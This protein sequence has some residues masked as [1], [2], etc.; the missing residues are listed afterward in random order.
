MTDSVVEKA[1]AFVRRCEGNEHLMT[2][3]E[4]EHRDMC[5]ALLSSTSREE[6]MREALAKAARD[7]ADIQFSAPPAFASMALKAELAI[8]AALTAPAKGGE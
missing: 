5:A 1:R 2:Q 7:F 8:R 3:T 4:T 6:K